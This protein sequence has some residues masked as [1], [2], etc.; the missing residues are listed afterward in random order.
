M[1]KFRM[2]EGKL[3]VPSNVNIPFIEGDGVGSEI[4]P[5][6]QKIVNA[7]EKLAYKH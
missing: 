7:T 4:N 2:E 6:C 5:A 1:S 3:V